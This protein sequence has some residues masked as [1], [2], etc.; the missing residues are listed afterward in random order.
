MLFVGFD[1]SSGPRVVDDS[2][3]DEVEAVQNASVLYVV[4]TR[5]QTSM[6]VGQASELIVFDCSDKEM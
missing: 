3:F 2:I 6:A 5:L 4:A 1:D